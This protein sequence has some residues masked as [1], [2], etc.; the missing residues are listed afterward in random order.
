MILTAN[1]ISFIGSLVM[2]GIGFIRERRRILIAQCVQWVIMSVSN[3]MLGGVTGLISTAVSILRNLYSLKRD[4]TRPVKYGFIAL[5]I[6]ISIPFNKLGLLGW[7]PVFAAVSFTLF[8]D[9]KDERVLKLAIIFGQ[10]L[11]AV[12]DF[13]LKNYAAFAFDLFTCVSTLIGIY[14]IVRARKAVQSADDAARQ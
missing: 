1:I 13:S 5:Q 12:F 14:R 10:L 7:L 4:L 9:F 2:V 11:W 6:A 8:L 3:L